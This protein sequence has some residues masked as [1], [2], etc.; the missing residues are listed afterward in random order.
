M[1]KHITQAVAVILAAFMLL[2]LMSGLR[3]EKF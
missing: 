1:K 2:G 3:F